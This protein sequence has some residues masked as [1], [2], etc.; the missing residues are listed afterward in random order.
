[1]T[2][3][4]NNKDRIKELDQKISDILGHEIDVKEM[5]DCELVVLLMPLTALPTT[6][7]LEISARLREGRK[8]IEE[9][10]RIKASLDTVANQI[11]SMFKLV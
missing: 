10:K 7:M 8:A 6:A 5:S 4:I 3:P 1:M 9:N 2:K 11:K